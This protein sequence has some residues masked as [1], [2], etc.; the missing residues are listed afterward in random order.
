MND[1][2]HAFILLKKSLSRKLKASCRIH[3]NLVNSI[4]IQMY[5]IFL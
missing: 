3:L 5:L 1:L 2:T 4:M